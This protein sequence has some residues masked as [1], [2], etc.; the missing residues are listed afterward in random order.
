MIYIFWLGVGQFMQFGTQMV[1]FLPW[2][3]TSKTAKTDIP[4]MQ[5]VSLL[6]WNFKDGLF[7]SFYEENK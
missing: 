5:F 3:F 4:R 6:W 1:S 2:V 7:F